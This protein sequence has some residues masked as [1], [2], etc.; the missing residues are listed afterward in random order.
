MKE[1]QFERAENREFTAEQFGRW[2]KG[3]EGKPRPADPTKDQA[4]KDYE[5]IAAICRD[6]EDLASLPVVAVL[7]PVTEHSTLNPRTEPRKVG[8]IVAELTEKVVKGVMKA[9]KAVAKM[10]KAVFGKRE[11]KTS[12]TGSG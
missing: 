10:A 5:A 2:W 7:V 3:Q 8:D 1:G 4:G 11:A 6:L 9:A 12:Y